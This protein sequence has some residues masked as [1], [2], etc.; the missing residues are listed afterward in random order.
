MEKNIYSPLTQEDIDLIAS[1]S[2]YPND[3]KQFLC[4]NFDGL[5][6]PCSISMG[7]EY[8]T[9]IDV[10]F[11]KL[12]NKELNAVR[13]DK[14]E[15][16]DI[17]KILVGE[18]GIETPILS[19]REAL[20]MAVQIHD[21]LKD[22]SAIR[23]FAL[24]KTP[25]SLCYT[26]TNTSSQIN[27]SK[28]LECNSKSDELTTML[29]EKGLTVDEF[30][31]KQLKEGMGYPEID[32][33]ETTEKNFCKS[34]YRGGTLGANPYAVVASMRA[35][36]CAYATPDMKLAKYYSHGLEGNYDRAKVDGLYVDYGFIYEFEAK[37]DQRYFCNYGIEEGGDFSKGGEYSEESSEL[38]YETPVFAH[39][40][41]LKNIYLVA[42]DKVVKI[43]N[44]KGE[45]LN[46]D[47]ENFAQLHET[48][49]RKG[50]ANEKNYNEERISSVLP[51]NEQ[52]ALKNTDKTK[53]SNVNTGTIPPPMPPQQQ[54]MPP[55]MPPMPPQQQ[56][57][58]PP[59]P[60]M[61]PQQ[62]TMPP[63]MPPMPSQQQ[64]VPPPMPPM[65]SQQQTVTPPR[66]ETNT[67]TP[68]PGTVQE[69]PQT[70]LSEEKYSKAAEALIEQRTQWAYQAA[71]PIGM[72][73]EQQSAA[74]KR[75]KEFDIQIAKSV[76]KAMEE[77]GAAL[78]A[79]GDARK[80]ESILKEQAL[81]D[82]LLVKKD[83]EPARFSDGSVY[84]ENNGNLFEMA[85]NIAKQR[86]DMEMSKVAPEKQHDVE[87][88]KNNFY[89]AGSAS[90]QAAFAMSAAD[91]LSAQ[92]QQQQ[93]TT[94][95]SMMAQ[96]QSKT[97]QSAPPM[98]STSQ[99]RGSTL[100]K[101]LYKIEA[102][103]KMKTAVLNRASNTAGR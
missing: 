78:F 36:D 65:P 94:P 54:T 28:E 103:T 69:K 11:D 25:E 44:D 26:S 89:T 24:P 66:T 64:T 27:V 2:K 22:E 53:P 76:T 4:G 85:V 73:T 43:T 92:S 7:I 56:T 74:I 1:K 34:L 100:M 17:N 23:G 84:M 79:S 75:Q 97:L 46:K 8:G 14:Q 68:H 29:E 96:L 99:Y 59:M 3:F 30:I 33:A 62:Q 102:E 39:Q 57:M 38:L 49:I 86:M 50:T 51:R 95:P 6:K 83:G 19:P 88:I 58:P 41:P 48:H 93:K 60:P 32:T 80:V 67:V 71:N 87:Q 37:E 45:Y 55:P 81:K 15:K 5:D 21:V 18:K 13:S 52:S 72:P 10:L 42:N 47:W 20:E 40:N 16:L 35:K 82:G 91:K 90:K 61:P 77:K 98:Q 101:E 31:S 9:D 63:P 12:S 70:N